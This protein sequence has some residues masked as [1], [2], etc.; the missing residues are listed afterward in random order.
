MFIHIPSHHLIVNADSV[1]C[2]EATKDT[3]AN[4]DKY[5]LSMRLKDNVR[6]GKK[7]TRQITLQRWDNASDLDYAMKEIVNS[8]QTNAPVVVLPWMV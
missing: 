7:E 6:L 8:L 2:F 3:T 4:G 1:D 5:V